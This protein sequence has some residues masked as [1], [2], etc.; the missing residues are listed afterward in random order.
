MREKATIDIGGQ[1]FEKS[2]YLD[3]IQSYLHEV[4]IETQLIESVENDP[5][6]ETGR[7]SARLIISAGCGSPIDAAKLMWIFYENPDLLFD[8]IK[9]SNVLPTLRKK[10]RYIAIS[11]TSG[12]G[13]DI[14]IF[15]Y[16]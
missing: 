7:I 3:K 12:T 1:S 11:T 4:G 15:R 5:S 10:A 13:T 2:G 8:Q 6:Q 9:A 14:S 16:Y